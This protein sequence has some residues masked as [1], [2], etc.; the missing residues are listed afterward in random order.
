MWNHKKY[1]EME[2]VVLVEIKILAGRYVAHYYRV[3]ENIPVITGNHIVFRLPRGQMDIRSFVCWA[4]HTA[5][6][7]GIFFVYGLD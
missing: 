3:G 6:L 2:S 4:R 5:R 1:L 7:K